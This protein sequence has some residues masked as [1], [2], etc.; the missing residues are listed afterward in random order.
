MSDLSGK[1]LGP[2]TLEKPLGKGGMAAVYQAVQSSVGRKVAIK[3][4]ARDIASDPGFVERFEREAKIIAGLEHPHI[5]PVID[6]GS[7][8]G[9]PYIVMRYI[10]GGSLDD[11]LRK[12][13]MALRQV[14]TYITQIGSALDYAHRHGVVHRDLKP[15]NVLLDKDDNCYLTDFGIARIEGSERKLT[16]TG[17]VMGTPAYMSPEQAMGRAVDARSDIYTLGVMLYEFVCGKLPFSADTPAGLIFQHVYELPPPPHTIRSDLPAGVSEVIERALQKSPDM[18][19]GS[20]SEFAH[21]FEDAVRGTQGNFSPQMGNQATLV[22][23]P[24]GTSAAPR[25]ITPPGTYQ[26]GGGGNVPDNATMRPNTPANSAPATAPRYGNEDYG[27]NYGGGMPAGTM[28]GG[29]IGE[30]PKR[31]S[32]PVLLIGVI[33]ALVLGGGALGL[34]ALSSNNANQDNLNKTGTAVM[35]ILSATAPVTA[36]PTI[37]PSPEPTE[38]PN[39]TQTLIAGRLATLDAQETAVMINA[40]ATERAAAAATSTSLAEQI[41]TVRAFSANQTAVAEAAN[42]TG[43]AAVLNATATG[44]IRDATNTAIALIPTFD[45]IPTLTA[46]AATMNALNPSKTPAP[47]VV[48]A[49]PRIVTATAVAFTGA[50]PLLLSEDAGIVVNAL[51]SRGVI[52]SSKTAVRVP[53]PTT[54]ILTGSTTAEKTFYFDLLSRALFYDFALSVDVAVNSSTEST[55][56]TSC[57]MLLNGANDVVL[58]NETIDTIDFLV[59]HLYRSGTYRLDARANNTWSSR[60]IMSESSSEVSRLDGG[61]NRVTLVVVGT[62]AKFFINGNL[63]SEKTL[64]EGDAVYNGGYLGYFMIRGVQGSGEKCTFSNLSLWRLS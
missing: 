57:G 2:Y 37:T 22:P 10:E 54:K 28:A 21:A 62:N 61:I 51:I 44:I 48:T 33:A 40:T 12:G 43:T 39:A 64:N 4:M 50:D 55:G 31:K 41:A 60:A 56:A 47:L 13:G 27:G 58:E 63:V 36:T 19:Y 35:M 25:P 1:T 16:A 8:N 26:Q 38:T 59:Y 45:P 18:R 52:P 14:A 3:V 11:K 49:T 9:I 24:S 34:A 7:D 30:T 46:A 15:N 32:S 42:A 53:I 23:T 5:L 29:A 20:A 6:Y 17:T